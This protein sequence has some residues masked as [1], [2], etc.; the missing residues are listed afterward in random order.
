MQV[1][2]SV[3]AELMLGLCQ[4]RFKGVMCTSEL[5]RATYWP[6]LLF[7]HLLI[8]HEKMFEILIQTCSNLH[9]KEH[10]FVS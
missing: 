10:P 4:I 7:T 3:H 6:H 8:L 5:Q 2:Q 1:I 9:V